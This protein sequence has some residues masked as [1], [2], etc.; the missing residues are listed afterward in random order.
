VRRPFYAKFD[1]KATWF[2]ELVPAFGEKTFFFQDELAAMEH[3]AGGSGRTIAVAR[4]DAVRPDLLE[5]VE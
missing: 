5:A 2:D 3:G 4:H 1:P